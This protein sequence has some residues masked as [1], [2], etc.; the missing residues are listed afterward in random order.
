MTKQALID[1]QNDELKDAIEYLKRQIKSSIVLLEAINYDE[2]KRTIQEV[3]FVVNRFNMGV[4]WVEKEND[5]LEMIL[6]T[7]QGD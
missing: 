3:K 4:E 1:K 7:V 5:K 2:I 6:K